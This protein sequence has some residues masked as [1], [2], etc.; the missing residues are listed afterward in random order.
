MA[1]RL[2]A[3]PQT[4]MA[5]KIALRT[6]FVARFIILRENRKSKVNKAIE[7]LSWSLDA[8]V[9]EIYRV[10]RKTLT[11][12]GDRT[13]IVDRDL[14][15]AKAYS[16]RTVD[17]FIDQYLSRATTSFRDALADYQRSSELLGRDESIQKRSQRSGW[18][19]G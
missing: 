19:I 6:A 18:R 5:R 9:D 13:Q 16:E 12:A 15:R 11:E 14:K 4:E 8:T 3:D 2:G 1:R 17:Y 7:D 10:I